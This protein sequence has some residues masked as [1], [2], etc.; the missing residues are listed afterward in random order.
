MICNH[1]YSSIHKSTCKYTCITTPAGAIICVSR[2]GGVT[3]VSGT[4]CSSHNH[5]EDKDRIDA[6]LEV[7]PVEG[8]VNHG[9]EPA[10]DPVKSKEDKLVNDPAELEYKSGVKDQCGHDDKPVSNPCIPVVEPASAP[11]VAVEDSP[12]DSFDLDLSGWL[13]F[14]MYMYLVCICVDFI[15]VHT[16]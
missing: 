4:D 14:V 10:E 7:V 12:K 11:S 15:H 16:P 9:D 13:N 5:A 1:C 2:H 8:P 3:A 6:E